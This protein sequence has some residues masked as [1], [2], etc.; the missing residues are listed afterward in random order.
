MTCAVAVQNAA[1]VT[2][3]VAIAGAF[4]LS[5]CSAASLLLLPESQAART[6]ALG[7]MVFAGAAMICGGIA[8]I[9]WLVQQ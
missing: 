3:I 2:A 7:M 8:L 1:M 9:A 4:C 5:G 6:C